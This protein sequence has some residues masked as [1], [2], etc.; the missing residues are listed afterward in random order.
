[1]VL[2]GYGL[3][4][5]E[6]D[7]LEEESFRRAWSLEEER[8][9]RTLN[10]EDRKNLINIHENMKDKLWGLS[11]QS[12]V[13]NIA[14]RIY[15]EWCMNPEE[16]GN[17]DLYNGEAFKKFIDDESYYAI[18]RLNKYVSDSESENIRNKVFEGL[19][20]RADEFFYTNNKKENLRGS[21]EKY[22]SL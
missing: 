6:Q 10:G 5:N 17:P 18:K 11:S 19:V 22:I 13:N 20:K 16:R 1:M 9:Y 3:D 14:W 15:T 8:I 4:P 21:L 12:L 2:Y 7:R